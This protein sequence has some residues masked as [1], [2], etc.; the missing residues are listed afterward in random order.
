MEELEKN[1]KLFNKYK[2]LVNLNYKHGMQN[3]DKDN[4]I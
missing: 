3:K 4:S 2:N 1:T